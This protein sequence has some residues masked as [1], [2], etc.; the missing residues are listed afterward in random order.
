MY[1]Y[2]F[3]MN[4]KTYLKIRYLKKKETTTTATKIDTLRSLASQLYG[5]LRVAPPSLRQRKSGEMEL[6]RTAGMN[7]VMSLHF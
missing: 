5:R 3:I 6:L 2:K 4:A 1:I 7:R